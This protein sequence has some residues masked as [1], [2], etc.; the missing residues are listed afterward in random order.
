M[1]F[2]FALRLG[3]WGVV[4]FGAFT[5]LITLLQTTGFYQVAGL[6]PAQR[7]AFGRSMYVLANQFT[8]LIAGPLR[9]DTVAGY[10]QWRAYGF[11][12]IVF[13]IWALASGVS[14]A[15]GDEERGLTEAVLATGTSRADALVARF[16]AFAV[17]LA[18][19]LAAAAIGLYLG[20]DHA[21]DAVD[22][23]AVLAASAL[24][25]AIGLSCYSLTLL[26]SQLVAPRLAAST[27]GVVLLVLFLVNSVGRSLDWLRPWRWLSPFYYYD[28]SRPLAPGGTFDI[29]GLEILVAIAVVALVAAILAVAFR[30][31]GAPLVRIPTPA[32]P[33]TYEPSKLI[34]W[35]VAVVRGLYDRR[36]GLIAWTIGVATLA[37]LFVVLTRSIVQP[38]LSITQLAPYFRSIIH[39][40]IY[41]SFLGFLWFG[42]AELLFAA[43][44][45]TQVARWSAEDG[46]GR[47]ELAL[48]QPS[49]RTGVVVERAA[50]LALG[51]VVIAAVGGVVLG[52]ESQVQSID[53]STPKLVEASLLLVPFGMFFAAI[54]AALASRIPRATVGL[55]AAYAFASYFVQQIGPL[56]KWPDWLLNL[57]PFKLYGQPLTNGLDVNGL[58]IM[59]AVTLAGLGGSVVLMNRRDIGS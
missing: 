35:R 45:I 16:A 56:F 22:G 47:L 36:A 52:I 29:R 6:T 51:L 48:S 21:H 4:G 54:G 26:V 28:L 18:V 19:A 27:A 13:A 40:E 3:R 30:D 43:Y 10:V 11:F 49:S 17:G 14:A 31:V 8:V 59:L 33:K 55:L 15:R 12:A 23:G 58:A 46:D 32:R 37:A 50:V 1:L 38:V 20:L 2:R 57:S 44:A 39:G 25:M 9:P 5:F 53:V 34:L 42:F 41:P 24:G 7:A